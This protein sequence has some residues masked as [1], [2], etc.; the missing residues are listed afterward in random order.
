MKPET[1]MLYYKYRYFLFLISNERNDLF[2]KSEIELD[3]E[4]FFDLHNYGMYLHWQIKPAW[5]KYNKNRDQ[6][7]KKFEYGKYEIAI[8]PYFC[9]YIK[10][11]I[12]SLMFAQMK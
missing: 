2:Y 1:E 3:Y 11:V 5:R 6:I 12:F 4:K 7:I 10:N 8:R 9:T